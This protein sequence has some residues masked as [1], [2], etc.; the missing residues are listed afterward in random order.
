MTSCSICL[1]LS[2][3]FHLALMP[4]T[5]KLSQMAIFL[6][7]NWIVFHCLGI[8][9]LLHPF[10]HQWILNNAVMNMRVC[11][12]LTLYPEILLNLFISSNIFFTVFRPFYLYMSSANSDNFT[13]SFWT[14]NSIYPARSF[15]T[16]LNVSGKSENPWV[17]PVPKGKALVFSLLSINIMLAT[18]F[19]VSS[20]YWY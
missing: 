3:L 12:V 13:S 15:K 18:G 6:F 4:S 2:D 9:H 14:S 11:S 1:S 20:S 19:Q 7:W 10:I 17:I 8:K 16:M 5:S